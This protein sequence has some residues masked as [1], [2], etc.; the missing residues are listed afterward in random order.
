MIFF[1]F[2]IFLNKHAVFYD[3]NQIL[4]LDQNIHYPQNHLLALHG[5]TKYDN[6]I[7]PELIV[8]TVR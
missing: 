7:I 2:V 1:F 4:S 8:R 3:K 5:I 6:P